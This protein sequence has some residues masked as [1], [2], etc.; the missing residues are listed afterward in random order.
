M[1]A[2]GGGGTAAMEAL[3]GHGVTRDQVAEVLRDELA[4]HDAHHGAELAAMEQRLTVTLARELD[5][6]E[7]R[8]RVALREAILDERER[9]SAPRRSVA[10]VE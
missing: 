1:V 5:A 7:A 4:T 3:G 9:T 2:G 6:M 10:V 8:Q